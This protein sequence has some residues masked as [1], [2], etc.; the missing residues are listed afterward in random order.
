MVAYPFDLTWKGHEFLAAMRQKAVWA[1]MKKHFGKNLKEA[2]IDTLFDV[3]MKLGK[4]YA[5]K[6]I[7]PLLG[8]EESQREVS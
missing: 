4:S 8:I 5:E 7:A 1:Q 2:P 3:A 6:K